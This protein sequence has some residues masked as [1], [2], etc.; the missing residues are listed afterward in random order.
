MRCG[1][2]VRVSTDDQSNSITAQQANIDAYCKFKGIEIDRVF[3]DENVSGFL[4]IGQRPKGSEM[5]RYIADSGIKDVIAI[6]HD[7]LFRNTVDALTT[8]S[9]WNSSGITLHLSNVGGV[10]VDT[11]TAIGK[12]IFTQIVSFAEFERN[13]TAE[14]TK[15]VLGNKKDNSKTYAPFLL[16]FDNNNGEM[17]VVE[18]E[19]DVVR[20]IFNMKGSSFGSIARFLNETGKETK[21]GGKFHSST[22]KYILENDI[23]EKYL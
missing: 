22:V 12:M 4:A 13:I 2:Y 6:R 19:M 17:V 23:Y 10:S 14:R 9:S 18:K 7:R 16:G 15:T 11:A 3:I 20:T 21:K 5:L 8:V 1:V